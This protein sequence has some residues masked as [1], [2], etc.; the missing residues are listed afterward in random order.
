MNPD[1]QITMKYEGYKKALKAIAEKELPHAAAAA[2]NRIAS[3]AAQAQRANLR[4]R[5]TLRNRYSEGSLV[6]WEANPEKQRDFNKLNAIVGSKQPYLA[7]QEEGGVE[8]AKGRTLAMPTIAGRGGSMK[9]A[10]PRALR[11]R[12]M[13]QIRGTSQRYTKKGN[14]V[15]SKGFFILGPG[16]R[17]QQAAIFRRQG[18][19]L[20]KLRLLG[21]VQQQVRP[22]HWHEDAVRKYAKASL[23]Q[24]AFVAEA[25]RRIARYQAR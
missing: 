14:R 18:G 25:K 23:V 6:F 11:L 13:G 2:I 24:V 17:L 5:F 12:A 8:R 3:G 15:R 4:E 7:L 19:T 20:T 10:I 1:F 16:A 9:Y 22:R 21:R